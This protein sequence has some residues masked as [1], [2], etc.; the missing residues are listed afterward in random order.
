MSMI[1]CLKARYISGRG[2]TML[3]DLEQ[4]RY[5]VVAMCGLLAPEAISATREM[6]YGGDLQELT[7]GRPR[8]EHAKVPDKEIFSTGIL[9]PDGAL[10]AAMLWKRPRKLTATA[11]FGSTVASSPSSDRLSMFCSRRLN[12]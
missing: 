12:A 7:V 5:D 1:F 2:T 11:P 9:S 4:D 8:D 6:C 3:W 10:A